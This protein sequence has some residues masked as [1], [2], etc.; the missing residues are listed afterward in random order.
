MQAGVF[1]Q[2]DELRVRPGKKIP[3]HSLVIT[4]LGT[5]KNA[6]AAEIIRDGIARRPGINGQGDRRLRQR[7]AGQE[8]TGLNQT[9]NHSHVIRCFV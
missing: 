9:G 5:R 6:H 2:G 8:T 3:G 1:E 4:H 7:R